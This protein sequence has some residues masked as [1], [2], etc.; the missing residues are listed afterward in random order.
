MPLERVLNNYNYPVSPSQRVR[1]Y[2][3]SGYSASQDNDVDQ[4]DDHEVVEEG[5]DY[6]LEAGVQ[7]KNYQATKDT[8]KVKPTYV[9]P[10]SDPMSIDAIKLI[11]KW[12]GWIKTLIILCLLMT[13]IAVGIRTVIVEIKQSTYQNQIYELNREINELTKI[14]LD[15]QQKFDLCKTEC[16]F[17][18]DEGINKSDFYRDADFESPRHAFIGEGN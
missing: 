11:K 9:L 14:N 13:L 1:R 6:D 15:W 5:Y 16:P 10:D 18:Y 3:Q 8:S 2:R 4:I 17:D 12:S 7:V